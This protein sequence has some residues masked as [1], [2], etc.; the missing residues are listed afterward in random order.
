MISIY[1]NKQSYLDMQNDILRDT[2]TF[3]YVTGI[4]NVCHLKNTENIHYGNITFWTELF[5]QS[6][7][8]SNFANNLSFTL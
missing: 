5:F 4:H 1:M 6:G 3:G 7:N 2:S 8:I